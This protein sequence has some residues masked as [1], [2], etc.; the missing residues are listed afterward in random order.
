MPGVKSTQRGIGRRR[1]N[2]FHAGIIVYVLLVEAKPG[3]IHEGRC[4]TVSLLHCHDLSRCQ[5]IETHVAECVRGI[6][7]GLV[8]QVSAKDSVLLR[9]LVID[10]GGEEVFVDNLL[11]IE[12]KLTGVVTWKTC[13]R[14]R[15]YGVQRQVLYYCRVGR[16][17]ARANRWHSKS[18]GNP[19]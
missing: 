17:V 16:L 15:R 3:G 19:F 6:V 13:R 18:I 7:R 8:I 14:S 9:K 12:S 2:R 10:A 1:I 4:K 11:A 5:T